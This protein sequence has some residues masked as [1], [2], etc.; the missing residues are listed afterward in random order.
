MTTRFRAWVLENNLSGTGVLFIGGLCCA[1]I[2]NG[3]F[4]PTFNNYVRD[5]FQLT[6]D[7]RGGLEFPR[8]LPGFAVAAMTGLL[9][10]LPEVRASAIAVAC[11]GLGM[12]GLALAGTSYSLMIIW[13][14]VWSM[15]NHLLMPMHRAVLLRMAKP[16]KQATLLGQ[17]GSLTTASAMVGAGIVYW[18]FQNRDFT[19]YRTAFF[20]GGA[21]ALVGVVVIMRIRLAQDG[22]APKRSRLVVKARYKVYY[23]LCLLFGARK[24]VFITFGPWVLVTIF[25]KGPATFAVLGFV[26]AAISIVMRP[27]LGALIDRVGERSVLMV[28]GIALTFVCL[29]YGFGNRISDE[30][31]AIAVVYIC[32]VADNV[33]FA[34]GMARTTYLNKIAEA[35]EDVTASLA[36]GTTTD[37]IVSMSIPMLGGVT[38]MVYGFEYVFLGA[39]VLAVG[40]TIA[41]SF[42]RVPQPE[43]I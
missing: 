25:N 35:P 38:W 22:P 41:A 21:L 37:H 8:E 4:E 36:L 3:I 20:I 28:D 17:V 32:Y 39:A 31:W 2:A 43:A 26:G 33:L 19:N 27:W 10:F 6:A 1:A 14:V 5:A 9:F 7:Q 30:W 34:V 23:L 29:G 12:A 24:Q 11:I 40:T 16:G 42:I 13:M 18:L 15:G